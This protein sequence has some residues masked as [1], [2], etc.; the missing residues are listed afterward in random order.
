[1]RLSIAA[2]GNPIEA[3]AAAEVDEEAARTIEVE[4][5]EA[6]EVEAGRTRAVGVI[7][8]PPGHEA[9]IGRW[10]GWV[11]HRRYGHD[12]DRP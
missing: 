4:A 10:P 1:M 8:T 5:V 6:V 3:A 11:R 7:R 12:I 2:A 9:T